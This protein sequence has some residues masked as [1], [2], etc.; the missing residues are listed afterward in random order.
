MIGGRMIRGGSGIS[1]LRHIF[2]VV[3][4][5]HVSNLGGVVCDQPLEP[6][7]RL[8]TAPKVR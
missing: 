5:E 2:W 8:L 1:R 3:R 6:V 4:R 7:S